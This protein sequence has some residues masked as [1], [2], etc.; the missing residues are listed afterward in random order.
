MRGEA[1]STQPIITLTTDFGLRGS[2]VSAMKGVILR[3]NLNALIVDITH[4]IEPQNVLEAS[5]VLGESYRYFPDGTIHICVVD[6]GVG[7]SRRP[8]VLHDGKHYFVGPDNGVFSKVIT[9]ADQRLRGYH[10]TESRY[11]LPEVS[12]TFHGRDVFAPVAAWLSRWVSCGSFGDLISDFTVIP[13]EEP[14]KIDGGVEGKITHTDRFGNL[15]TN[16]SADLIE[17][18]KHELSKDKLAVRVEG[19]DE[20]FDLY[21][22]YNEAGEQNKTGALINSEGYLEIFFYR[23]SAQNKLGINVGAKVTLCSNNSFA[24]QGEA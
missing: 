21:S 19:K 5:R 14:K 10:I 6:P 23:G 20:A 2:F 11:F 15:I 24:R 4:E 1:I 22:F 3:I 13:E 8:V 12:S 18:E 17:A 9:E 16:I 7:S